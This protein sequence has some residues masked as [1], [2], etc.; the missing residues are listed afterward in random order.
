VLRDHMG[1]GAGAL[2]GSVFPDSAGVNAVAGLMR[3]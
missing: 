3:A 1:V 2:N